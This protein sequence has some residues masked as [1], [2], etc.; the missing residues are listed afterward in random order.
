MNANVKEVGV[1]LA[2]GMS[3]ASATRSGH[4]LG[5]GKPKDAK[6]AAVVSY[7]RSCRNVCLLR[8]ILR[9]DVAI[10]FGI[11]NV[12][13]VWQ[14]RVP[15]A[16]LLTNEVA[17]VD[18]VKHNVRDTA[19]NRFVLTQSLQLIF[20]LITVLPDMIAFNG[21]GLLKGSGQIRVAAICTTIAHVHS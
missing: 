6:L 13:A 7:C 14:F 3:V 20:I 17:V 10:V 2:K 8:L 16:H 11:L 9:Q 21:Y 18:L 19:L 4:H 5:S 15:L 12:F 1:Q